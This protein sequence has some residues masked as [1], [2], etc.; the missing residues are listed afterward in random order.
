MARTRSSGERGREG[1]RGGGAEG[2][3][4]RGTDR[5]RGSG[6]GRVT[7]TCISRLDSS[8]TWVCVRARVRARTCVRALARGS[9]CAR[10]CAR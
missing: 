6:G 5:R 2:A 1:E 4:E 3:R 10:A 8:S 7:L 9:V